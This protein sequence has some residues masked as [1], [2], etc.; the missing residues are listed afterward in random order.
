MHEKALCKMGV[1][2]AHNRPKTHSC[3]RFGEKFGAKWETEGYFGGFDK[4]Y[5]LEGIG[6][7]KDRWSRCIEQKGEYNEK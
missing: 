2:I 6:K 3:D 7:L 1:A 5:Y 4:S